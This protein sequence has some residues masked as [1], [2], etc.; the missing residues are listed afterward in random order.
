MEETTQCLKVKEFKQYSATFDSTDMDIKLMD[1]KIDATTGIAF[2]IKFSSNISMEHQ[3][4]LAFDGIDLLG[5]LGGALGLFI[6][7]SF[8]GCATTFIETVLEKAATF[9]NI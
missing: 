7:F 2:C 5:S 4:I 9:F 8:F 6:G 1:W 3:E